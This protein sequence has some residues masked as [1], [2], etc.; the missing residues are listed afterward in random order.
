MLINFH[1]KF[2]ILKF[3]RKENVSIV[4]LHIFSLIAHQVLF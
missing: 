3:E 4:K 2:K 1:I